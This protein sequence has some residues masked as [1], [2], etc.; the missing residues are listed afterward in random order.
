MQRANAPST[1]PREHYLRNLEIPFCDHLSA[2]FHNRFNPESRKG[3]EILALLPGIIKETGNVQHVVDGLMF[4]ESDM[5]N[6]SSLRAEL[7]EWQRYLR[8]TEPTQSSSSPNLIECIEH[9][10]EGIFP[11]IRTLLRIGCTLLVGSCEAECSFPCLQ[12]VKT[13]LCNRMREDRLSG[14]T[15]MNMNH[16]MQIDL[17]A[18]CQMFIERNKWKMFSSYILYQ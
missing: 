1:S 13:Y 7:K 10:D 3:I 16:D 5:P 4:L 12:L 6:V 2:E 11:N 8:I 15:V 14:L 17:E 18:V 9:A